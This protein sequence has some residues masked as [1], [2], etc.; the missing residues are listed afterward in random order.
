MADD[1]APPDGVDLEVDAADLDE[2]DDDIDDDLDPVA[3][4]GLDVSAETDA[5]AD[6]GDE[7]DD[8]PARPKK[9]ADGEDEED[10]EP[11]PDD[12][13]DDLDTILKDR[14]ASG[15]DEDEEE[16]DEVAKRTTEK[17]VEPGTKV[18]V[19]QPDEFVCD[20]CFLV[21]PNSQLADAANNLCQDCV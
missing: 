19:R 7:A 13:E 16:D 21:K 4:V 11:D 17:V 12:V 3:P 1:E 18:P 10:D 6:E 2:L 14:I 5:D 20:S 9:K 8:A 15:E